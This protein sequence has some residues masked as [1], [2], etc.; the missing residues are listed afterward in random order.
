M[1]QKSSLNIFL[2]SRT[3]ISFRENFHVYI[4]FSDNSLKLD[5]IEN[6][7]L[8]QLVFSFQNQTDDSDIRMKL[9]N[10][11]MPNKPIVHTDSLQ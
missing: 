1:V 5:R 9:G 3:S 11:L 2:T 7:G 4:R 10:S 8:N 6:V